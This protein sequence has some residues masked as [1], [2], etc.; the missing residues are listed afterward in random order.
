MS[1]DVNLE[2]LLRS[3][4]TLGNPSLFRGESV[5]TDLPEVIALAT[6]T[7][8]CVAKNPATLNTIKPATKLLKQV[9][10][11]AKMASLPMVEQSM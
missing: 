5:E 2:L 9:A 11:G 8:D 4:V 1:H 7:P 10:I 3:C 6:S